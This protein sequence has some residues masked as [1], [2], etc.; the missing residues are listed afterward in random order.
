VFMV[1]TMRVTMAVATVMPAGQQPGAGDIDRETKH[2]NRNRL[3]EADGNRIEQAGYRFIADQQRNHRQ[4]DGAGISCQIAE[5]AG[6]ERETAIAG[7]F[8][9]IGISER[10]EQ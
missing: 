3:I 8:A 9:G 10:G 7:I 5:L 4:N 6:T 1:M 2:R